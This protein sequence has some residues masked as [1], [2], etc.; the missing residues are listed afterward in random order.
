MAQAVSCC[1]L[2]VGAGIGTWSIRVTFV[3]EKV[4]LGQSFL[5]LRQYSPVCRSFNIPYLRVCL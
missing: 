4:A 2:T 3:V 1:S 5:S